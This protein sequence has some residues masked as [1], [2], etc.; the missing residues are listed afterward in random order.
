MNAKDAVI[1]FQK[2]AKKLKIYNGEI[3]G[4]P[5]PLTAVALQQYFKPQDE[6][7]PGWLTWASQELGVSEIYGK[8]ANPRIVHYHSFTSLGSESDEVAWCSS[9]VNAGLLEGAN[10]LGTKSAAAASFRN[11]GVPVDPKTFAAI[12]LFKTNTGSLRHVAF[13]SGYWKGW[14]F[15]LGGNQSNKVKITMRQVG[16][17]TESRFPK[18]S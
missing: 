17:V 5:G 18:I 16:E 8:R 1:D 6:K 12:V 14:L 9:F 4:D 13:S 15:V 7:V 11:Y 3:D 2:V 10:I